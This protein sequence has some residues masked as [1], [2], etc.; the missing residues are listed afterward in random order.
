[1]YLTYL[2]IKNWNRLHRFQRTVIILIAILFFLYIVTH[3]EFHRTSL[4][5]IDNAHKHELPRKTGVLLRVFFFLLKCAYRNI[6]L[7]HV[8]FCCDQMFFKIFE[9]HFLRQLLKYYD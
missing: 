7:Q 2:N 3:I 4:K 6:L 8:I 9:K 5:N 1:M